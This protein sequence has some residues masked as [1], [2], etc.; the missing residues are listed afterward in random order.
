MEA[1]FMMGQLTLAAVISRLGSIQEVPGNYAAERRNR[2][3]AKPQD[4]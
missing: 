4:S 1:S 3:C 2:K